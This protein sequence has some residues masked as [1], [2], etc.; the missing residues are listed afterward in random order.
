MNVYLGFFHILVIINNA[1]VNKGMHV[2]FQ[3]SVYV[4]FR[5]MPKSEIAG[6]YNSFIFKFFEEPANFSNV[7]APVYISTQSAQR[8]PVLSIF[9]KTCYLLSF[10]KSHLT[11]LNVKWF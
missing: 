7:A 3:I 1:A 4:Y 9:A 11:L 8:F 2:S 6:L 5:L 10:D